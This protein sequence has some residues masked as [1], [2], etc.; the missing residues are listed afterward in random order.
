[1]M[2]VMTEPVV[3]RRVAPAVHQSVG[4]LGT[5]LSP[6]AGAFTSA[7]NVAAPELK[8]RAYNVGL[9]RL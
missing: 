8:T 3:G 5:R 9:A 1:M 7:S 6:Y 2:A 4:P